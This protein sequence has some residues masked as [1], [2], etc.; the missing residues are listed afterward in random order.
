MVQKYLMSSNIVNVLHTLRKVKKLPNPFKVYFLN[1]DSK[2]IYN[3]IVL[4]CIINL[5]QICVVT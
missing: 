4:V 3:N 5:Y 1:T 2:C